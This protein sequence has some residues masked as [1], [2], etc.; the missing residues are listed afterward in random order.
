MPATFTPDPKLEG[1]RR[2]LSSDLPD[3]RARIEGALTPAVRM[4]L[5][6]YEGGLRAHLAAG[7]PLP[8]GVIAPKNTTTTEDPS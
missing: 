3:E 2:R 1:L 6:H 5:G 4:A 7:H 8:D